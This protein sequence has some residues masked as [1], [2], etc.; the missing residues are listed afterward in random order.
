M[1]SRPKR[2][3]YGV[4]MPSDSPASTRLISRSSLRSATGGAAHVRVLLDLVDRDLGAVGPRAAL[5]LVDFGAS[6]SERSPS[7]DTRM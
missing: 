5:R 2:S 4:R 1:M 7:F 3:S 6:S